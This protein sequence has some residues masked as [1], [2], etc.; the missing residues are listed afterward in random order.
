MNLTQ[1]NT[2]KRNRILDILFLLYI[3]TL[4]TLLVM[5][6]N[7]SIKLN[8]YFLG[9]RTDHFIHASLFL[10]ILPYFRFKL[11]KKVTAT[12]FLKYFSACILFAV[13][14][15]FLQLFVPYRQFDPTDIV[16]NVIGVSLGG[17]AFLWR[18]AL[19]KK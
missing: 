8:K 12:V 17:L 16:A 18:Q 4:L 2:K 11:V 15:E 5:P 6:T 10:P 9:I 3:L 7:E 14:C 1:P 13:F 19:P